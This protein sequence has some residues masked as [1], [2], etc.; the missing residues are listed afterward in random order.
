MARYPYRCYKVFDGE[1][2]EPYSYSR[3]LSNGDVIGFYTITEGEPLP[4]S[5]TQ[6][7]I[8]QYIKDN[9]VVPEL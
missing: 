7:E 4:D 6:D 5:M 8:K 2:E 3:T 1:V 9:H